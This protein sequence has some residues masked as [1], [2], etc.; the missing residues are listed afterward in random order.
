MILDGSKPRIFP[1]FPF[2]G[3]IHGDMRGSQHSSDLRPGFHDSVDLKVA[4]ALGGFP[5]HDADDAGGG[6]HGGELKETDND[7]KITQ[8][9]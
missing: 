9:I 8:R 2:L 4:C 1:H 5:D 7:Q 6:D 3:R